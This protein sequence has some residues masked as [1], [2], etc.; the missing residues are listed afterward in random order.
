MD[1]YYVAKTAELLS[2]AFILES[3]FVIKLYKIFV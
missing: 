3:T 1:V 2:A